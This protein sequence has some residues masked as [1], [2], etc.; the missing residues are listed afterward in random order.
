[1]PSDAGKTVRVSIA[2]M[3]FCV[4]LVAYLVA[5]LL[6]P[7]HQVSLWRLLLP[8]QVLAETM[9]GDF[10]RVNLLDRIPV[11]LLTGLLLASAWLLGQL[12]LRWLSSGVT[13]DR[14]ERHLFS[15]ACGLGLLSTFTLLAGLVGVGS[16]PFPYLLLLAVAGLLAWRSRPGP[17]EKQA[18][19]LPGAGPGRKDLG[20]CW[21]WLLLPLG[22]VIVLGAMLPPLD[23][24]VREYHMQV[25]REWHQQGKITF[26][27]HNVYGNMPLGVE[28]LAHPA[29]AV[30]PGELDWW[31]GSLVG[32]TL[33]GCF[34]ILTAL[35]LMSLGT[36][37]HGRRAGLAS[38][39]LYLSI[40]WVGLVSM[41]GLVEGVL[42]FYLVAA[43]A[44]LL[45]WQPG[46]GRRWPVMIGLLAGAAAACKYPG[47]LWGV[48]PALLGVLLLAPRRAHGVLLFSLGVLVGCGGWYLKNL[49]LA[50]NPFYPLLDD[51]FAGS[52]TAE[53]VSQWASA[54]Q[55]PAFSLADL[56]GKLVDFGGRE[57]F[58]GMLLIPCALVGL[59][60]FRGNR[61]IRWA[62][63]FTA[64]FL[65]T[66]WLLTHHLPR[67]WVPVLPFVA[68]LAGAG[69]AH[70]FDGRPRLLG[71]VLVV[72]TLAGLLVISNRVPFE[73]SVHDNRLL[74]SLSDLR[75]GPAREEEPDDIMVL[76]VHRQLNRMLEPGQRV[77]LV[78]G[79]T[80]FDLQLPALY[81]TCFDSCLLETMIKTRSP[82]Q[83][84]QRFSEEGITHV[85]VQWSAIERYR[86]P[87]NYG[88][89]DFVTPGLFD[90][91]AGEGLLKK[92]ELNVPRE[93]GELFLVIEGP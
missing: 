25:P 13:L 57:S 8:D 81:N 72:S 49:F 50:G 9:G 17:A 12:P 41:N 82:Q 42:G 59:R 11:L 79:A 4:A 43:F 60:G 28:I 71:S 53:Q 5:Y 73:S 29:M 91:L 58:Q 6:V 47:M 16:S 48:L 35:M 63:L 33:V 77:L 51:W 7:I 66:W 3:I 89:T 93:F 83:R 84:R 30:W 55:V 23:F 34:A 38:A 2:G 68:L 86:G 46:E 36:R 15:V 78:G 85:F 39:V 75:D 10:A 31:W 87:G 14:L 54:H 56:L 61:G 21:N 44:A 80:P 52:R 19:P 65:V 37:L 22:L 76:Q 69:A 26:L 40:P 67:F 64:Y 88:F 32:K 24:D 92:V 45:V 62:T 1:M 18:A 90:E 27:H 20:V 70:L 74:V